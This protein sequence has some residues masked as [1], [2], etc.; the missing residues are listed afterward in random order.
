MPVGDGNFDW[1]IPQLQTEDKKKCGKISSGLAKAVNASV[2]I[3]SNADSI[4]SIK[5]KYYRPENCENLCVPRVNREIW[6]ALSRQA[7]TQDSKMQDIQK[8][9]VKGMIPIVQLAEQCC[10]SK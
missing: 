5:D 1:E 4:K 10:K 8:S 7:N 2:T 3:K 9:L 6:S